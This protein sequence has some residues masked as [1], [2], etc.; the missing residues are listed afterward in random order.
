MPTTPSA[1]PMAISGLELVRL[2]VPSTLFSIL[3]Q[4][5]RAVDQFWIHEVSTEAQAAIGSSTFVLIV[6]A[7]FFAIISAGAGP[8]I[9]RAEGAGDSQA[10]RRYIGSGLYAVG[11]ITVLTMLVGGLMA[12]QMAQALGLSGATATE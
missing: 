4:A 1:H 6:F 5:Y 9:A 8:L 2:A 3:R 7:G 11:L 10:V 12:P